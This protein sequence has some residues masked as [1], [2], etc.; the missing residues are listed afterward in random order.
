MRKFSLLVLSLTA[1]L[2][3]GAMTVSSAF[4]ASAVLLNGAVPSALF[5]VEMTG[6]FLFEDMKEPPDILCSGIFDMDIEAGGVTGAIESF[7]TLTKELLEV[8]GGGD[9]VECEEHGTSKLCSNPVD[10]VTVGLP[11]PF[12]TMLTAG[13]LWYL[14]INPHAGGPGPGIILDCNSI[15]GLIEDTCSGPTGAQLINGVSGLE[16]S[17]LEAN[18]E[19]TPAGNCT[20]GG[21]KEFL[22]LGVGVLTSPSGVVDVS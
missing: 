2:A 19:I 21:A 8:V 20:L 5:G 14:L 7:L 17:F 6:E 9:L 1:A 13:G 11:W 12:E 16:M 10:V 3:F 15:L 4:G 18:E 22:I